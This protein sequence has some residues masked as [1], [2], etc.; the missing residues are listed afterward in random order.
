MKARIAEAKLQP[1]LKMTFR[2]LSR[3]TPGKVAE[4]LPTFMH[5]PGFRSM[6]RY[7]FGYLS[8]DFC[9]VSDGRWTLDGWI[10]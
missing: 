5:E 1:A 8:L 4:V 7:R 9:N 2:K 10:G 3:D 6:R